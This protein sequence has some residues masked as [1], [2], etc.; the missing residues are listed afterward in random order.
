M[1][2]IGNR[3]R[4]ASDIDG[5]SIVD[6][7]R[8]RTLRRTQIQAGSL[9]DRTR[10]G[11]GESTCAAGLTGDGDEARI[12]G[13]A[14]FDGGDR[15][16]GARNPEKLAVQR[17]VVDVQRIGDAGVKIVCQSDTVGVDNRMVGDR[18]RGRAVEADTDVLVL[19]EF[20]LTLVPAPVM[21]TVPWL[22]TAWPMFRKSAVKAAPAA[23]VKLPVPVLPTVI[24]PVAPTIV[25]AEP[26]PDAVMVPSSSI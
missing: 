7:Q 18:Q 11:D 25:I 13:A 15:R 2:G 9:H 22:P 16:S 26:A 24:P 5:A 23:T 4:T 10:T 3:G 12:D 20:V 8:C 1:N 19:A 17:G 6:H 21:S 14:I